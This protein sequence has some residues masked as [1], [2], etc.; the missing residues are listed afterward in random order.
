MLMKFS[1]SRLLLAWRQRV[2]WMISKSG[3]PGTSFLNLDRGAYESSTTWGSCLTGGAPDRRSCYVFTLGQP[4]EPLVGRGG[5]S[6]LICGQH[7]GGVGAIG[8]P[9]PR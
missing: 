6:A 9:L 5:A 2:P 1:T 7:T 3:L 8:P 4:H